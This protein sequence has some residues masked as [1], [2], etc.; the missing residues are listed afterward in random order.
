MLI[1]ALGFCAAGPCL[2]V[3][4]VTSSFTFALAAM[5]VFGLG[6]GFADANLMPIVC[7]VINPRYAATAYGTLAFVGVSV[8][9]GMIYAGGWLRDQQV[10]LALPFVVAAAG[11]LGAGLMLLAVKPSTM[12]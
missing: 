2:A 7:Q 1:P 11:L 3:L 9:G 6:R 12:R 8:G 5:V 4:A 10:G